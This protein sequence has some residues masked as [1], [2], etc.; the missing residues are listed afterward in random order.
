M[1]QLRIN[2]FGSTG[3]SLACVARAENKWVQERASVCDSACY[4]R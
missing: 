3:I 1:E 2:S 4:A